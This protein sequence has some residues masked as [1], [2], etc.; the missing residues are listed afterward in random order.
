MR[1]AMAIGATIAGGH[2]RHQGSEYTHYLIIAQGSANEIDHWLH[3]IIDIGL[4]P[5]EK[6]EVLLAK[7]NEVRRILVSSITTLRSKRTGYKTREE[8][9]LYNIDTQLSDE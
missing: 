1:S 5:K 4:G 9:E 3:T 6:I 8:A 2:G 7:N